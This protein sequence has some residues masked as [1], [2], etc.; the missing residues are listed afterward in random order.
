MIR[1]NEVDVAG[2]A[3]ENNLSLALTERTLK[4][5]RA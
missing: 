4:P 5:M 1:G 2:L 3:V